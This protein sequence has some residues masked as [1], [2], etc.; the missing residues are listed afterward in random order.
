MLHVGIRMSDVCSL[1]RGDVHIS[2]RSGRAEV[3]DRGNKKR[4][5]PLNSTIR[6]ILN[7]WLESNGTGTL[8]PNIMA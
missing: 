8:F 3:T 7:N 4:E 5:V 2:D 1:R 6:K